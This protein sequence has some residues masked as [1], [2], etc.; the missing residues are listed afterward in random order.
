[1]L[2]LLLYCFG[3]RVQDTRLH[4]HLVIGVVE[5]YIKNSQIEILN[6]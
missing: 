2:Q 5:E 3:Q 4:N 1:M 6:W